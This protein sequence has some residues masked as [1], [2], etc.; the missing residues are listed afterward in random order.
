MNIAEKKKVLMN[1]GLG[2]LFL[3]TAFTGGTAYADINIDFTITPENQNGEISPLIYGTNH[4]MYMSGTE[5][6]G[7]FRIG[8]NRMT[9]Y[10]WEN[11]WSNAGS[12]W[13]QSSDGY[14]IPDGADGT[15]P[16]ITLTS[17]IDNDVTAGAKALVTLQMAGYVA[18]DGDGTVAEDET[19]P[20]GRW[21]PVYAKKNSAFSLSPDL[22]DNAVYMDEVVNFLVDRYGLA[23]DGGVF[24]YSLDNEP[25]LWSNTHPRIHP[26]AAG[27][28]ELVNRSIEMAAAVKD[29]DPGAR[30]FGPALFGFSAFKTLQSPDDWS[31]LSGQYAWYIDYYLDQMRQAENAQG[32]RLLDVMDLHWYSEATGDQ[33]VI[34]TSATSRN[35]QLARLQ[36]PRTLWDSDYIENSWIGSYFAS[37]LPLIPHLQ[38]SIDVY[39]PGTRLAF[40]EYSHGGGDDIT[41]AVAQ[42]DT[43][44]IFGKYGVYASTVWVLGDE[45]DYLGAAYRLY[46]NYD[47]ADST[48]GDVSVEAGMGDKE[49]SSIYAAV[50]SATDD[51]HIIVLNKNL[52]E[53][54]SG[55]FT[56]DSSNG[57]Q[58]AEAYALTQSSTAIQDLGSFQITDNSFSYS[59]PAVSAY[60]LVLTKSGS[61]GGDTGG[62]D[63]GGGGSSET[64]V[65]AT[66]NINNDWGSGYCAV[67]VLENT[68]SS[69]VVW[70]VSVEVDGSVNNL[71]NGTWSQSGTTLNVSG[72]A[73]N[74]TLQPGQT[75]SSVGFCASR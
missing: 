60:H 47:G 39:Y 1:P 27:A 65:T 70:N 71:W 35:D 3:L 50:D 64:G 23:E 34:N 52:D 5:N 45:S 51:L 15:I 30:I 33:R 54:V 69:A 14:M 55:S 63:T 6:F 8:G 31:A 72:V 56:I 61:S 7:F 28:A 53:A 36:A 67:L 41:G 9:G 58:S 21:V 49:N 24:A 59:I 37:D 75:D 48:F 17:F 10:N 13:Q 44:G 4:N 11:N 66:V 68:G 42:A 57:Y 74:N 62:G 40:T 25:A 26:D 43:L 46:R 19:A 38:D 2:C 12:D 73:W 22:T 29:V 16:G 32:R 20:S 18:A